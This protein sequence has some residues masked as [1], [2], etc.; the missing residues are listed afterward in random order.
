MVAIKPA[1]PVFLAL[2][3]LMAVT[4]PVQAGLGGITLPPTPQVVPDRLCQSDVMPDLS[5]QPSTSTT[6]GSATACSDPLGDTP[7]LGSVRMRVHFYVGY[8]MAFQYEYTDEYWMECTAS[9]GTRCA[10]SQHVDSDDNIDY[11]AVVAEN[12]DTGHTCWMDWRSTRFAGAGYH[13]GCYWP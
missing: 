12:I 2:A 9:Y 11:A 8:Y 6:L 7:L 4:P 5:V 10:V 1:N 13:G 3:F